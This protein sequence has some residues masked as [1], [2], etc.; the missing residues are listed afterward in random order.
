M[1]ADHAH[2]LVV[3]FMDQTPKTRR[4][5]RA[6]ADLG[7]GRPTELQ[8]PHV[9]AELHGMAR[10]GYVYSVEGKVW[11]LTALGKTTREAFQAVERA[12]KEVRH[13]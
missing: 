8:D 13:G 7:E 1:S 4:Y 6:C 9:R 12:A 11:F 3:A 2:A 10:D 5:M